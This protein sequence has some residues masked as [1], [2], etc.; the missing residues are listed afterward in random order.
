[1]TVRRLTANLWWKI[2][3][4]LIA[5]GLWFL[6]VGE[7]EVTTIIT[8]PVQYKRTLS[9]LEISSDM[10]HTVQL[11]V[12]G[13]S[14]RLAAVTAD[15][16]PVLL[17]LSDLREAGERTFTITA[18]SVRLPTGVFLSRVIPSQLRLN[19]EK[20]IAREVNVR[21][22]YAG[23]PPAGYRVSA[24]AAFPATVFVTGPESHVERVQFV[25]TDPVKLGGAIGISHFRVQI[26]VP[27][28]QVAL[29]TPAP[30]DVRVEME[31]I[32]SS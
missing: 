1:M 28:A 3:S 13:P 4:L 2:L 20:R 17:D 5:T 31:K 6:L 22:R 24:A 14:S 30:V 19:L 16:S 25:E 21:I 9:D 18:Q 8:V 27:D 26:Y 32:P 23:P 11:E 10:P 29:D 7:P 15:T 12:R